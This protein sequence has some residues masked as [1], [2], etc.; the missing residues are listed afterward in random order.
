MLGAFMKKFP[1][2]IK[3]YEGEVQKLDVDKLNPEKQ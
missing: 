2:S 3:Y 1:A